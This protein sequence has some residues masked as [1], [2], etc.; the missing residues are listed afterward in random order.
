M[1]CINLH[2]YIYFYI[3]ACARVC[4]CVFKYILHFSAT[5]LCMLMRNVVCVDDG[6]DGAGGAQAAGD[7]GAWAAGAGRPTETV[8]DGGASVAG[9]GGP[10]GTAGASEAGIAGAGQA[11]DGFRPLCGS[12][13]W[14]SVANFSWSTFIFYK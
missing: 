13:G 7:G 10:A 11:A 14:S 6:P 12:L 1:E 2:M 8:G 9:D 4:M 3:C 5:T